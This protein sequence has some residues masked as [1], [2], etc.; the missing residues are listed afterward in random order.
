MLLSLLLLRKPMCSWFDVS[1]T[2]GRGSYPIHSCFRTSRPTRQ[3]QYES[4]AT[5]IQI[6]AGTAVAVHRPSLCSTLATRSKGRRSKDEYGPIVGLVAVVG[7][8]HARCC[9][10][11]N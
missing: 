6:N 8:V 9:I 4:A 3:H 5:T 10:L 1:A 7:S 11:D 2:N